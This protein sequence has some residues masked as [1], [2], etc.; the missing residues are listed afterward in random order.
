MLLGIGLGVLALGS[1]VLARPPGA[2]APSPRPFS[3]GCV[4][5]VLDTHPSAQCFTEAVPAGFRFEIHT[6]TAGLQVGS[7]IKPIELHAQIATGGNVQTY[8]FP[9]TFMSDSQQ[10]TGDFWATNQ[11][12]LLNADTGTAPLFT[13]TLSDRSFGYA[14]IAVSGMLVPVE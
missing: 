6:V 3:T 10:F 8:F 14:D 11:S 7:G 9:A 12:V 5:E 4:V 13:V 1:T 2:P